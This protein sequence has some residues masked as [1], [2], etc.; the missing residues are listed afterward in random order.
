VPPL[1]PAPSVFPLP[2]SGELPTTRRAA[3]PG[4]RFG[5]PSD[6][7]EYSDAALALELRGRPLACAA[8]CAGEGDAYLPP[9][10][11]GLCKHASQKVSGVRDEQWC[12]RVIEG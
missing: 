4:R 9:C 12:C 2:R 11:A 8:C 6:S 1:R 7:A 3:L 5:S 10:G